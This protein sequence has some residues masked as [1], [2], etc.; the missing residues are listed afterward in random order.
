MG[1]KK[2]F[3]QVLL[4][5]G[6]INVRTANL[7]KILDIKSRKGLVNL[8]LPEVDSKLYK[9]GFGVHSYCKRNHEELKELKIKSFM[10]ELK[11]INTLLTEQEKYFVIKFAS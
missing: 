2:S 9:K 11:K 6:E 8:K 4:D 5:S 3:I 10:W 1:I 7:L